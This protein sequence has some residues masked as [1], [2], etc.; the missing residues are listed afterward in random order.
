MLLFL[1]VCGLI[2]T[3]RIGTYANEVIGLYSHALFSLMSKR[4]SFEEV[5]PQLEWVI[6]LVVIIYTETSSL[7]DDEKVPQYLYLPELSN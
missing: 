1:H 6:K 7:R 2:K 5:I 4:L 3:P